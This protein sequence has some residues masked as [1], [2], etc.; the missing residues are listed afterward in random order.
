MSF[1]R[2][3][4]L[5]QAKLTKKSAFHLEDLNNSKDFCTL[6]RVRSFVVIWLPGCVEAHKKQHDLSVTSQTASLQRLRK[7]KAYGYFNKIFKNIYCISNPFLSNY[8]CSL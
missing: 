2:K 4:S 8:Y 5:I 7:C 1:V 6:S 3:M